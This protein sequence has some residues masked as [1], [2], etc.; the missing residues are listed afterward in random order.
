M[1][2][3]EKE[4]VS[5]AGGFSA[6][7]LTYRQIIRTDKFGLYVRHRDKRIMDFEVFFIA[8]NPK[9]Q[10]NKFPNGTVKI[11]EDDTEVYPTNSNFGRTAWTTNNLIVAL[12]MFDRLIAGQ[13]VHLSPSAETTETTPKV[14]KPVSVNIADLKIPEGE[15][16]TRELA[17]FNQVLYPVAFTFLKDA[18]EKGK[19]KFT[20]EERRNAKGKATR[21]FAKT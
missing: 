21:L 5:G 2:T 11:L 19:V 16:S 17:E 13:P 10:E 14:H 8:V 20:R 1:I 12:E 3:L 6:D 9:G 18:I 4:F 15:F 7:P